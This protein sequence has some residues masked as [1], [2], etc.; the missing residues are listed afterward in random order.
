MSDFDDYD[1]LDAVRDFRS[2]VGVLTADADARIRRRIVSLAQERGLVDE[3]DEGRLRRFHRRIVPH[4]RRRTRGERQRC[5]ARARI[6][7]RVTWWRGAGRRL[8]TTQLARN[9]A[10]MTVITTTFSGRRATEASTH[11]STA[12]VAVTT[13]ARLRSE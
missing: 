3:D 7:M 12:A 8:V 2:T 13:T 9:A 10:V 5:V 4:E 1:D 11:A 6:G